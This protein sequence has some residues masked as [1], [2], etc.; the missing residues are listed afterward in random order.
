MIFSYVF[1]YFKDVCLFF[2]NVCL[3]FTDALYYNKILDL[4]TFP[5]F[6]KNPLIYFVMVIPPLLKFIV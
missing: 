2:Y 5:L 4:S 3:F 1:L 6:M